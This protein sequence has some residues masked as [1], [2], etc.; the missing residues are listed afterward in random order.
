MMPRPPVSRDSH[1]VLQEA[2]TTFLPSYPHSHKKFLCNLTISFAHTLFDLQVV[3]LQFS[4]SNSPLLEYC[5]NFSFPLQ[6]S[7][8]L[9]VFGFLEIIPNHRNNIKDNFQDEDE[10]NGRSLNNGEEVIHKQRLK[11]RERKKN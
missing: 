5:L 9:K 7:F 8:V 3:L 2:Q 6:T 10:I 1:T 11:Q 4:V